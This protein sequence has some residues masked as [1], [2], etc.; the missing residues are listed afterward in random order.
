MYEWYAQNYMLQPQ[1]VDPLDL[2][3]A[4]VAGRDQSERAAVDRWQR[5]TVEFQ[6]QD[7]PL[8]RHVERDA[9]LEVGLR[10]V[11]RLIEALGRQVAGV[12]VGVDLQMAEERQIGPPEIIRTN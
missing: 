12:G 7:R 9:V 3:G 5:G 1:P 4:V 10:G 8:E 6:R 11:L 2:H